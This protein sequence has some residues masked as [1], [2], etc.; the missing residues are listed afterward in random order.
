MWQQHGSL[1]HPS[2]DHLCPVK[3]KA[4][5]LPPTPQ[6]KSHTNIKENE[7]KW[8]K[9]HKT[10]PKCKPLV[11]LVPMTAGFC[12]P[13]KRL[14]TI[15]ISYNQSQVIIPTWHLFFCCSS[16]RVLSPPPMALSPSPALAHHQP[17]AHHQPR[18]TDWY[19]LQSFPHVRY[20]LLQARHWLCV[21]QAPG[22]QH[23]APEAKACSAKVETHSSLHK[24]QHWAWGSTRA[25]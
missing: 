24:P 19:H 11:E 8:K 25:G 23:S 2:L 21:L 4:S 7:T 17:W 6:D 14:F 12:K 18:N 9:S 16:L 5:P 22:S 10:K 1:N 20:H 13:G 15:T 3:T